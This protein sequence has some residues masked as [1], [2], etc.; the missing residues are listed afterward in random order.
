[1][2]IKVRDE[3]GRRTWTGL[4]G[5]GSKIVQLRR[6]E[7]MLLYFHRAIRVINSFIT[8]SA[9]SRDLRI[10]PFGGLTIPFVGNRALREMEVVAARYRRCNYAAVSV[11]FM[12]IV[13]SAIII[14]KGE[15]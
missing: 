14:K 10:V 1:M 3:G 12:R 7:A 4:Q 8:F 9:F 6:Y 5:K 2:S 15:D 13:I 11:S